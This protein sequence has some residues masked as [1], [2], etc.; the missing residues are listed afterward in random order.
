MNA[1]MDAA[2]V[3]TWAAPTS[4]FVAMQACDR[5][6][7]IPDTSRWALWTGKIPAAEAHPHNLFQGMNAIGGCNP[8]NPALVRFVRRC[9]PGKHQDWFG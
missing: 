5:V 7:G 4:E 8:C 3:Q 1:V 9:G 6:V 2:S